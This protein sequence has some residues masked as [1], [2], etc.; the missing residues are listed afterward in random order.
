M[1]YVPPPLPPKEIIDKDPEYWYKT[2]KSECMQ[3][4]IQNLTSLKYGIIISIII[5]IVILSSLLIK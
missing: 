1:G 3:G 4:R 5:F 2:L